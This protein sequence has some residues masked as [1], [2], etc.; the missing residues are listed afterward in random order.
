MQCHGAQ[1]ALVLQV[2]RQ[3]RRQRGKGGWVPAEPY[4]GL[5]GEM[6]V[7]VPGTGAVHVATSVLRTWVGPRPHPD[8]VAEYI[9][10]NPRNIAAANLRWSQPESDS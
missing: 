5:D 1:R 10:G 9:D 3:Q 6:Y 4:A 7:D 8:S 2:N